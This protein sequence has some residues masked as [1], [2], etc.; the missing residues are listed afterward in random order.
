[1][2]FFKKSNIANVKNLNNDPYSLETPNWMTGKG[3]AEKDEI[4]RYYF[5]KNDSISVL[6]L[7]VISKGV[8]ACCIWKKKVVPID[9]SQ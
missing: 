5:I 9:R 3:T 1:L 7:P 4:W 8:K 6:G 2:R